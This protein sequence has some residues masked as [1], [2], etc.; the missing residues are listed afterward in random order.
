MYR[1]LVPFLV[2]L[3]VLGLAGACT[4]EPE[5]EGIACLQVQQHVNAVYERDLRGEVRLGRDAI[6]Q[7]QWLE[8]SLCA[9]Q[10]SSHE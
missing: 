7:L 4:Q 6:A 10:G 8:R 2:A 5:H 1:L 3:P 9:L